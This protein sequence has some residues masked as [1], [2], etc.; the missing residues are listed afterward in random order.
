M[1]KSV[2]IDENI[3]IPLSASYKYDANITLLPER[4]KWTDG[5]V[6]YSEPLFEN[7]V[8]L[9][10]NKNTYTI[11]TTAFSLGEIFKDVPL[12]SLL[13]GEFS[14]LQ[15]V[16]TNLYINR[17]D[18]DLYVSLSA[19]DTD[20][21]KIM[22]NSD[23]TISLSNGEEY[24]TVIREAPWNVVLSAKM[25]NDVYGQQKFNFYIQN[26]AI[27]ISTMLNPAYN[28]S[29]IHQRFI[30]YSPVTFQLRAIGMVL[31]DDYTPHNPYFISLDTDFTL[32]ATLSG[33]IYDNIFV[34][35]Y[36]DLINKSNNKTTNINFGNSISAVKLNHLVTIPYHYNVDMNN[37]NIDINFNN[38]KSIDT[39]E[40][41]TM[42]NDPYNRKY[43]RIYTGSN[44]DRG[45][46]NMYL[47]YVSDTKEIE[48]KPD[49]MTYFHYPSGIDVMALSS[50]TFIEDGAIAGSC[51]FNADKIWKKIG[52]YKKY[53]VWGDSSEQR[54]V[55][56]CSWL[57]GAP[58]VDNKP[59]WMDRWYNPGTLDIYSAY[60]A[61]TGNAIYDVPSEMTMEP[62]VQYKYFRIG[63]KTNMEFVA[64]LSGENNLKLHI[65]NWGQNNK[66]QS[67]Y[68]NNI[69]FESTETTF[70]YTDISYDN[71]SEK[72]NCLEMN[73]INQSALVPYN[74]SIAPLSSMSVCFW[75]YADD[76][77]D[78]H[79]NRFIDNG[80]RGG[81]S[82]GFNNGLYT[83]IAAI[84]DST[85]GHIFL[86]NN[87]G[88]VYKNIVLPLNKNIFADITD[89][90]IDD[91]LYIWCLDNNY[92]KLYKINF[93]GDIL[94]EITFA[95]DTNLTS[96]TQN[97]SGHIFVLDTTYS[98]ISGFNSDTLSYL[99]SS[100]VGIEHTKI[101][102][103]FDDSLKFAKGK[104]SCDSSGNSFYLDNGYLSKNNTT[105]FSMGGYLDVRV[106]ENDDVW[107]L[108]G[109][110]LVQYNNTLDTVKN[111]IVVNEDYSSGE[112]HFNF[113]F[114]NTEKRIFVI[115]PDTNRLYIL[116]TGGKTLKIV[117]LNNA[118]DVKKYSDYYTNLSINGV[119]DFSGFEFSKNHNK[120]VIPGNRIEGTIHF[121]NEDDYY[122]NKLTVSYPVSSLVKND[123]NHFV[124]QYDWANK[125]VKL[126][127]NTVLRDTKT[128]NIAK[129]IYYRYSNA[130][131]IGNKQAEISDL[132]STI[133]ST[134]HHFDG[135][136]DDIRMYDYVLSEDEIIAI[137]NTKLI[138][139]SLFWNMPIGNH[140]FVEE[141]LYFF[142]NKIP[143]NKSQFYN[144]NLINSGIEDQSVRTIIE[145][146]IRDFI[147]K[148]SPFYST[149]YK[150]IWD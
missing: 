95:D 115:Y 79:G 75:A 53:S 9:S 142:K 63:N 56:L 102:T 92:K 18:N 132:D 45:Y 12:P 106:D 34:R 29:S 22:I 148:T 70:P 84:A 96:L 101:S 27:A 74:S 42:L 141:I 82:V 36:M 110:S 68:G 78:I 7:A 94:N 105:F 104:I 37:N 139:K 24:F 40:S 122:E 98:T 20:Y 66:D 117:N 58:S 33:S 25:D 28:P 88:N 55:W 119:N 112:A 87:D 30:S 65:D 57:S 129:P 46:E 26:N 113:L 103:T 38:T 49:R 90:M 144:I 149:L 73:G 120:F 123:W 54:G 128:L 5:Y 121:G 118:I 77:N 126:F 97:S 3:L 39:P 8:D 44:E 114:K 130:C 10:F 83:P 72:D 32:L 108:N 17:E 43:N 124:L 47:G 69:V 137:Y 76:W 143:G 116:N 85:Y 4:V 16:S 23:N 62:G 99:S 19:I 41:K 80:F 67:S 35:Y 15:F 140:N 60:V 138:F 147:S 59:V 71:I 93:T 51:P 11:L 91:K 100:T 107:L 61:T 89:L 48:F 134:Q 86:I 2:Y 109:T 135:K 6:S 64:S 125:Q 131:Y 50:S 81:W 31:D 146:V 1:F 21:Y 133:Y 52:N 14:F 136:I 127:V 150:I 145:N 13:L 111:T